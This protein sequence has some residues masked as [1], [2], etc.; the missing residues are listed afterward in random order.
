MGTVQRQIE[1][2]QEALATLRSM[3]RDMDQR[4]ANPDSFPNLRV[5][6]T[7]EGFADLLTENGIPRPLSLAMA[8]EEFGDAQMAVDAWWTW[9][10]CCTHCCITCQMATQ[11][12]DC[13]ETFIW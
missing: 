6:N 2:Y 5:I 12:T 8:A 9:D 3:R 1:S 13:P 11:V 10:C 4:R 7:A